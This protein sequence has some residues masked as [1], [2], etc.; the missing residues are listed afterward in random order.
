MILE[1]LRNPTVISD[2]NRASYSGTL[3]SPGNLVEHYPSTP[4]N[5]TICT[6]SGYGG[7]LTMRASSKFWFRSYDAR[8]PD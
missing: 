5:P 7:N 1:S 4:I 2:T 8:A 6:V 3:L